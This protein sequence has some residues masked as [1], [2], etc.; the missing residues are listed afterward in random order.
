M[1]TAPVILAVL[2]VKELVCIVQAYVGPRDMAHELQVHLRSAVEKW[3]SSMPPLQQ[4]QY[5]YGP[6][7]KDSRNNGDGDSEDEDGPLPAR[8]DEN[9]VEKMDAYYLMKGRY[10]H[11]GLDRLWEQISWQRENC[12]EEIY[13]QEVW[14]RVEQDTVFNALYSQGY[15]NSN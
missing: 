3:V 8:L 1:E 6:P 10:Y 7:E 5:R 12:F 4:I 14:E 2:P 11:G 15:F 9:K 13:S